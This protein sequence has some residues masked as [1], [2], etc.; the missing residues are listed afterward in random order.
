MPD[1]IT[2]LPADALN[3]VASRVFPGEDVSRFTE[4]LDQIDDPEEALTTLFGDLVE[5]DVLP[6]PSVQQIESFAQPVLTKIS[7]SIG[8][9]KGFL[10]EAESAITSISG[11]LPPRLQGYAKEALEVVGELNGVLGDAE[12]LL[13]DAEDKLREYGGQGTSVVSWLLSGK[14]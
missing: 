10:G 11:K 7:A 13:G 8:G 9:A 14:V 3:L 2:I 1:T 4:I 6:L 5:G 12:S